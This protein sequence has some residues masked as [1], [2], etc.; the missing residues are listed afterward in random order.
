VNYYQQ[1]P[2]PVSGLEELLISIL[3]RGLVLV[4]RLHG[5][6]GDR[7]LLVGVGLPES[8]DPMLLALGATSLFRRPDQDPDFWQ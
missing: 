7:Q 6:P 4:I 3:E 8:V 1:P 2:A 5:A